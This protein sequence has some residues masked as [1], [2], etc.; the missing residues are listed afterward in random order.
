MTALIEE[1]GKPCTIIFGRGVDGIDPTIFKAKPKSVTTW[2][3]AYTDAVMANT[4]R[5]KEELGMEEHSLALTLR[6]SPWLTWEEKN[7]KLYELQKKM[8]EAPKEERKALKEEAA[9]LDEEV[10]QIN[11][12]AIQQTGTVEFEG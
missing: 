2:Q 4:D 5:V 1:A 6:P 12:Q 8:L 9:A 10:S 7:S 11:E 3:Q